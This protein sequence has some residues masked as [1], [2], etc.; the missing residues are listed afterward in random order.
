MEIRYLKSIE[1][2]K[3]LKSWSNQ[4]LSLEKI[5][6]LEQKYNEGKPFPLA[7]REFLYLAGENNTIGFDTHAS[8]ERLQDR[9]KEALEHCKQK[10]ERPFFAFDQLD[11]CSQFTFVYL[12]EDQND[13]EVYFGQP[14]YV[15]Y[16]HPLIK[17]YSEFTFSSLVNDHIYRI[18]ND[19][20]LE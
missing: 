5:S 17:G 9:S 10:I 13:P 20:P 18:K 12:D 7:I 19:I 1:Q 15:E 6:E 11:D 4:G 2:N 3:K 8:I 14:Y 16:G